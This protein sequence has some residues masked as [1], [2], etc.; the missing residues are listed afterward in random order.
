[1]LFF[2]NSD[3]CW[4]LALSPTP[5]H[6]PSSLKIPG[7]VAPQG[8]CTGFCTP[9]P[10]LTLSPDNPMVSSLSSFPSLG[11]S[12][13]LTLSCFLSIPQTSAHSRTSANSVESVGFHSQIKLS[14]KVLK[15]RVQWLALI[16]KKKIPRTLS[17]YSRGMFFQRNWSGG[18]CSIWPTGIWCIHLQHF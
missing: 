6:L 17:L 4:L 7:S 3:L 13:A 1:M 2:S 14:I 11:S 10:V 15:T 8:L 5:P 18:N 12:S 16:K 9:S